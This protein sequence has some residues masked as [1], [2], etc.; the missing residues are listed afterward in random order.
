MNLYELENL[1]DELV[2]AKIEAVDNRAWAV[3]EKLDRELEEVANRIAKL[4]E[5]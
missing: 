3:V 2:Y 4:E 5:E 1:L